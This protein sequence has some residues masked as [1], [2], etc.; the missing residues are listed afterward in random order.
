MKGRTWDVESSINIVCEAEG[1]LA[2][3][4]KRIVTLE[5]VGKAPHRLDDAAYL[6][7]RHHGNKIGRYSK[8]FQTTRMLHISKPAYD[9]TSLVISHT[10][11]KPCPAI[12]YPIVSPIQLYTALLTHL[13]SVYLSCH[14]ASPNL[15]RIASICH[16]TR[17][18]R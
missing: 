16:N 7:E 4:I 15:R 5:K 10:I 8:A 13:A 18:V 9:R 12:P 11:T 6:K 3:R 2:D 17:F 14:C 1:K